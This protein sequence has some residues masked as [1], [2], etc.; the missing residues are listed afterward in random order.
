MGDRHKASADG[1]ETV[2]AQEIEGNRPQPGADLSAPATLVAVCILR[3]QDITDPV[4]TVLDIPALTDQA[5]VL[6]GGRLQVGY[7]VVGL[8]GVLSTALAP[9]FQRN[10]TPDTGPGGQPWNPNDGELPVT[11]ATVGGLALLGLLLRQ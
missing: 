4:P 6:T 5:Q 10:D 2:E 9:L 3:Q 7:E 1:L 8:L 11:D